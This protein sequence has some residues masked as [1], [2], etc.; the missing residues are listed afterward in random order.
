MVYF[1]SKVYFHCS[2]YVLIYILH[3]HFLIV[4][5]GKE[6]GKGNY[7]D[8]NMHTAKNYWILM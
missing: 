2:T 5:T 8:T 3:I 6:G 4:Q 1:S 7:K